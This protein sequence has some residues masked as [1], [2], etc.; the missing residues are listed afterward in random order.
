MTESQPQS[1]V[2]PPAA[3]PQVIS[4]PPP[5]DRP[6]PPPED[7]PAAELHNLARRLRRARLRRPLLEYLRARRA[8]RGMPQ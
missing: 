4:S 3:T 7:D 8:A 1:N 5:A 2:P 6:P